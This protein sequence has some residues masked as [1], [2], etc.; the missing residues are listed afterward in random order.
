MLFWSLFFCDLIFAQNVYEHSFHFHFCIFISVHNFKSKINI[1]FD[2]I[3][4]LD[5]S[6]Y[7]V[8]KHWIKILNIIFFEHLL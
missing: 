7:L 2:V 3:F 1:L 8:I 4:Q 6:F 5:F